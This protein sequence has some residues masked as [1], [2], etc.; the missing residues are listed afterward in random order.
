MDFALKNVANKLSVLLTSVK[1]VKFPLFVLF[2][3]KQ[4]VYW[5]TLTCYVVMLGSYVTKI[6]PNI[7]KCIN[8][9]F[10]CAHT[11]SC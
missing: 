5:I 9:P 2:L 1:R 7:V 6:C 11:C 8:F 3:Q 4:K 10:L